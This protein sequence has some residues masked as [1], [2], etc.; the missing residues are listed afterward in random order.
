MGE[1]VL[2]ET[3]SVAREYRPRDLQPDAGK[4]QEPDLG[5]CTPASILSGSVP[6]LAITLKFERA[7]GA[8]CGLPTCNCTNDQRSVVKFNP[9]PIIN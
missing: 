2:A 9:F 6:I 4:R 1:L 3:A 8:I 7:I 5:H